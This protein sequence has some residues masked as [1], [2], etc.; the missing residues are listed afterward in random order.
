MTAAQQMDPA[1]RVSYLQRLHQRFKLQQYVGKSKKN[2]V[3]LVRHIGIP[4][5]QTTGLWTVTV[6]STLLLY[7][8]GKHVSSVDYN[9]V[10]TIAA[11]EPQVMPQGEQTP[12]IIRFNYEMLNAGLIITSIEE[13]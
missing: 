3:V 8:N 6:V 2:C 1:I 10:L 11:I 7:E 4:K 12:E 13:I 5:E 9:H